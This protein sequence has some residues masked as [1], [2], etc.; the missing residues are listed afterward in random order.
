ME[1]LYMFKYQKAIS[2]HVNKLRSTMITEDIEECSFGTVI[3]T[4]VMVEAKTLQLAAEKAYEQT[5]Y[6]NGGRFSGERLFYFD[7]LQCYHPVRRIG[8]QIVIG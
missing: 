5:G 3:E 6:F 7:D 4:L 8:D 1:N 2:H